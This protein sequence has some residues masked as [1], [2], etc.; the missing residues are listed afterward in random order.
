LSSI[1]CINI[2]K[3]KSS[4]FQLPFI[5]DIYTLTWAELQSSEVIDVGPSIDKF[6]ADNEWRFKCTKSY[7]WRYYG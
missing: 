2:Q 5:E 1:F 6:V 7:K 4:I 3:E